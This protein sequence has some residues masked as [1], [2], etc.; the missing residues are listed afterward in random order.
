MRIA[1]VG[2]GLA[3]VTCARAL[4]G[5]G[6]EVR[7]FDKGRGLGGRLATRRI[8]GG[9][10]D[11]GAAA[12]PVADAGF[13]ALLAALEEERA[14]ARWTPPWSDSEQWVGLP[15]MSALVKALARG[16]E[17]ETG[18]RVAGLERKR[19]GW[20]L[21]FE[22]GEGEGPFDRLLLA[23]PQPQALE[24]LV[25][26]PEWRAALSQAEMA[27]CWTGLFAFEEAVTPGAKPLPSPAS[28]IRRILRDSAKPGR[29]GGLDCWVVQANPEWTVQN[30]E[31]E[32]EE[33]AA[34]LLAEAC[35]VWRADPG[36]P[37]YAAGHRWRFAF[38]AKPLGES[39]L[40]DASLGLGV[41]GDWCLGEE[42]EAAYRSGAALAQAV[43]SGNAG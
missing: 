14:V 38:T 32:K 41:C 13:S 12:L 9:Q 43:L 22:D 8:E 36:K 17:V 10:F 40:F 31:I 33:A 39:H 18:R 1:V 25:P 3:G 11:H 24:L 34:L 21:S 35:E 15:G 37:R 42:A 19:A 5:Q 23:I 30:L 16:L 20:F 6:H 2:A 29:T 26:W 4:A 27:P 28:P 7:M